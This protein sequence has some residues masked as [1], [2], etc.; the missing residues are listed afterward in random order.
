MSDKTTRRAGRPRQHDWGVILDLWAA[1]GKSTAVA[2]QLGISRNT[3]IRVVGLSRLAGD[4]RAV[5]R[6]PSGWRGA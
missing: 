6:G 4:P 2:R 3:V 5:E 1:G